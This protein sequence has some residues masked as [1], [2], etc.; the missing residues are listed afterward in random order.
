M[1]KN[2]GLLWGKVSIFFFV[3][4]VHVACDIASRHDSGVTKRK[5]EDFLFISTYVLNDRRSGW[6]RKQ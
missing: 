3:R 4:V 1:Y 2:I 6:R 5:V